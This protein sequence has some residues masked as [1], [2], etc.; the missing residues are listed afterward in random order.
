M[1]KGTG[2]IR[3]PYPEHITYD[4]LV[5]AGNSGEQQLVVGFV[6]AAGPSRGFSPAGSPS[7]RKR[8]GRSESVPAQGF[9]AE[10][11]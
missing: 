2:R 4:T 5:P 11:A 6:R 1:K 8:P 7:D 3:G 9:P 10:N